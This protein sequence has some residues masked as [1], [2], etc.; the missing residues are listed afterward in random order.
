MNFVAPSP[1]RTIACASVTA[2]CS[3]ASRIAFTRASAMVR[4]GVI[5][6]LPVDAITKLSFVDVSP[7][8]VAQLNDSSA[9]SRAIVVSTSGAI[10]ASVAM[11]DSIVAMS[12]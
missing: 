5:G 8:T 3:I 12:G 9:T 11:N 1:S 2:T 6:T 7:S 4:S 10:G